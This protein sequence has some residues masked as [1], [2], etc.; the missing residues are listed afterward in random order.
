MSTGNQKKRNQI[1][2]SSIVAGTLAILVSASLGMGSAA[3]G[4]ALVTVAQ[5]RDAG[6]QAIRDDNSIVDPGDYIDWA[7]CYN[8]GGPYHDYEIAR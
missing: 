8:P 4:N 5:C 7:R 1:I 6:G 3:A 2:R